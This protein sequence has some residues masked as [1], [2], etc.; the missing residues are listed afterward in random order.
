MES[1]NGRFKGESKS[2]FHEAANI[3]ELK[4]IIADQI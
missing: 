3:W 1:F 2:L 4:Q